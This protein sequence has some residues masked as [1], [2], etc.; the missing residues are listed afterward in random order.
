MSDTHSASMNKYWSYLFIKSFLSVLISSPV[1]DLIDLAMNGKYGKLLDTFGDALSQ[2]SVFFTNFL[3][4]KLFISNSMKLLNASGA[5]MHFITKTFQSYETPR[6]LNETKRSKSAKYQFDF[7]QI[8][9]LFT[10]SISYACINPIILIPSTLL[11][12]RLYFQ[13]RYSFIYFKK[14]ERESGGLHWTKNC[15]TIIFAI[16]FFQFST[17]LQFI[18]MKGFVQAFF[19][20]P[21]IFMSLRYRGFLHSLFD[22]R[23]ECLPLDAEE[24]VYIHSYTK[25]FK[26]KQMEILTDWL[27]KTPMHHED[28]VD[29]ELLL[30]EKKEKTEKS[31]DLYP[32]RDPILREI[33]YLMLP[34]NFFTILDYVIANEIQSV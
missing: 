21:C 5:F 1:V 32:Y 22:Q 2:K 10:M 9:V 13:T 8:M 3:F 30:E 15:W 6:K 24:E 27:E 7:P 17:F 23:S 28:T 33:S 29:Y 14:T 25:S 31:Q 16:F 19:L 4:Q 20:L 34:R 18:L 12:L 11:F 26:V